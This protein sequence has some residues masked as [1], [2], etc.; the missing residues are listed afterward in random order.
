MQKINKGQEP[1][2]LTVF[3][4]NNPTARYP[5][6]SRQERQDIRNACAKEQYYLCAYCCKKISGESHDTVNEHIVP[7]DSAPNRTLVFD[8]LVASCTT[9]KQCD[10]AHGSQSLPLTPLMDE[11][12][13]EFAFKINGRVEGLTLR[14]NDSIQILNLGANE[15]DNKKLVETRKQL[16]DALL[17]SYEVRSD[18]LVDDEL[19]QIILADIQQPIDGKLLPYAPVI[20]NIL[21]SWIG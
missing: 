1:I 20:A 2:S 15:R 11:C 14:A 19:L 12:E 21:K 4:R 5:D 13:T 17:F 10:D 18:D 7:Q 8:N 9:Q 3:R 16:V 6:L